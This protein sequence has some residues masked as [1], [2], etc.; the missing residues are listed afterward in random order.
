MANDK[1]NIK[2][3]KPKLSPYWIY[4][5]LIAVFLGFQLFSN[6][7]YQDGNLTTPSDFFRFLEDG[8]V[9]RVNIIKNTRVAKVYLTQEAESKEVHKNSKPTTLI[10]SATKLPNYKFEFGDLQNFENRLNE[11]HKRFNS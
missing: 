4:G 5:I 10:P 11:L 9:E 3:K 1:K 6:G 2:D 7:S 8:D